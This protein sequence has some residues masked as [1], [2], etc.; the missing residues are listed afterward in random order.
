VS[1]VAREGWRDRHPEDEAGHQ[2]DQSED[3]SD[4]ADEES[5]DP[6]ADHYHD[7]DDVDPVHA[8][9]ARSRVGERRVRR[10]A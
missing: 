5:S 4:G 7:D 10:R 8:F 9:K 3:L 2:S 6:R 1:D